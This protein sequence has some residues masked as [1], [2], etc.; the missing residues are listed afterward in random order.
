MNR[1]R[2][3]RERE[4]DPRRLFQ[5][6]KQI[7]L[8]RNTIGYKNFIQSVPEDIRDKVLREPDIQQKCSKRSWDGQVRKWRR[9]LHSWDNVNIEKAVEDLTEDMKNVCMTS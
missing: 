1:A 2:K 4:T 7:E 5:R 8:G 3:P 6:Q 9:G